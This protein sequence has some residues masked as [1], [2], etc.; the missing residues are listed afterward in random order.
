MWQE[1]LKGSEKGQKCCVRAK[2]DM[3]SPNGCLRDPTVSFTFQNIKIF[4]NNHYF[5]SRFTAVKTSLIPVLARNIS[6]FLMI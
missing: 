1:M 5:T 2:I 4:F 3:N 6:E